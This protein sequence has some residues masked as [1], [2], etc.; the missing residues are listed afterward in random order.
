MLGHLVPSAMAQGRK[1]SYWAASCPKDKMQVH[2]GKM[3]VPSQKIDELLG[4]AFGS[5]Y[6]REYEG[7][8]YMIRNGLAAA[9]IGTGIEC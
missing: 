6:I 5:D 7:L 8:E 3:D 9:H 1:G 4:A 2:V